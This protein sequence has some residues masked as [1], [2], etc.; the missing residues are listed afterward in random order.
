MGPSKGGGG[1]WRGGGAGKPASGCL[2]AEGRR[3]RQVRG[4]VG[5]DQG[6]GWASC[7]GLGGGGDAEACSPVYREQAGGQVMKHSSS[8][9][10]LHAQGMAPDG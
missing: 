3:L 8:V 9:G 4:G 7:I 1:G 2:P 6:G 10:V 5:R